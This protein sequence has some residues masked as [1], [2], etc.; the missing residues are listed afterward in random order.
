MKPLVTITGITGYIGSQVGKT[1]LESGDFR[2][3]GTVRSKSNAE[4][5]DPLKTAYG[6][7]FFESL[8]L[9]EADLLDEDSMAEAVKGSDYIVH[10]ASPFPLAPPEHED[11]LIKPAVEGT[12]SVVKAAIASGVTKKVVLTSSCASIGMG[13]PADRTTFTEEDWT[14]PEDFKVPDFAAYSKSKTFAEKKAWELVEEHNSKGDA[15]S[16]V[17]LVTI[18]PGLVI[19]P[20]L[21]KCKFS[22]GDMVGGILMGAMPQIPALH[23]PMVDVRDVAKA[24][25]EGVLRDEANGKR[26]ILNQKD[27]WVVDIATTLKETGKFPGYATHET[28]GEKDETG[29]TPFGHP[30][31][32]V[33]TASREV[34]GIEY[35]PFETSLVDM[36]NSL[37][38][39][40]YIPTP[41]A[42]EA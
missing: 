29:D 22:S 7:K 36:G 24:H 35:V 18:C 19:G 13:Y 11:D 31:E 12:T 27:R 30:L 4:K 23:Y 6:E 41:A 26:F 14:R 37:I 8:E 32:F 42:N 16:R 15:S 9:V 17:E 20:N 39:T 28:T 10:V 38:D 40:G 21:N 2:V 33:N 1:F 34:L 25:L 3:R 5:I